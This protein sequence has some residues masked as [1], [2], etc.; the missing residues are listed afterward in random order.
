VAERA[1]GTDAQ[2]AP[3][4]LWR[5]VSLSLNVCTSAKDNDLMKECALLNY[6]PAVA[7]QLSSHQLS[8]QLSM[9]THCSGVRHCGS[10]HEWNVL[11]FL[12]SRLSPHDA[13]GPAD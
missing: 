1:A 2:L 7:T 10:V 12:S 3:M 11:T 8:S 6:T 5:A 9:P 4:R 13:A